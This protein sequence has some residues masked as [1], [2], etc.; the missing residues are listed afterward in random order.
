MEQNRLIW[1]LETAKDYNAYYV[2]K[3]GLLTGAR[4][5]TVL[6]IKKRDIN[7]RERL[8]TLNNYKTN[9]TYQI[10]FSVHYVSFFQ[11]LF[12]KV[13]PKDNEHIIQP[14]RKYLYKGTALRNIP[15]EY[16][17]TCNKLFNKDLDMQDNYTR[18]NKVVGYHTLRHTRASS[19]A[20]SNIPL[21]IVK[22]FLNHSS[23]DSTLRYVK[24]DTEK[25]R[26]ELDQLS[27]NSFLDKD[28]IAPKKK[29]F[30]DE[31]F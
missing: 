24:S 29:V 17:D 3:I 27:V 23:L 1:E 12:K 6:G 25:M 11:A 31:P 15:R 18:N 22:E 19:L 13:N 8:I 10:P 26:K 7:L 21:H 16:F 2:A 28:Y 20:N 4:A 9:K 5:K 14:K 30:V